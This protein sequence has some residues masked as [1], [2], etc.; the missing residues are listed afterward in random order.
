MHKFLYSFFLIALMFSLSSISYAQDAQDMADPSGVSVSLDQITTPNEFD[1]AILFDN[2]PII[3]L[4]GGGCSG[5]NASIL[6][7]TNGS[8]STF[9]WGFQKNLFNWMADD[10]TSTQQW[11]IDSIKFFSYQTGATASSI[12]GVYVQI[13]NGAPNLGTSSVVWGDTVTNRLGYT[14]FSTTY[15]ALISTPADCNRRIQEVSALVN[16]TLPPGTYWVQFAVTGSLSS[17]PWC[18]PV[19]IAGTLV[20]GDALQKTTT[21]P[22]WAP[23]LNGTSQ[24]GAPFMIYGT[25]T[26]PTV[27]NYFLNHSTGTFVASV[28][29]DGF[30]GDDG[31]EIAAGVKFGALPNAMYTAGVVL[32]NSTFGVSGKVGSFTS[33]T[34][35]L[36]NDM[37]NKVLFVPFSSNGYFNQITHTTYTDSAAPV[38][39]YLDVK[40]TSYSRT[41]DNYMFIVYDVTNNTASAKNGI[42]VGMFADWDVGYTLYVQNRGGMDVPRSMTYQYLFNNAADPNYYGLVAL[43]GMTG[44]KVTTRFPGDG[45][46][47]R[48]ILYNWISTIQDSAI[49]TSGDYRSYIGSGPYNIAP[50]Q[51]VKVGYAMVIGSSLAD[52]QAKADMAWSVYHSQIVPVELTSFAASVNAAGHVILN[53]TTGTEINNLLFEVER[54]V[55]NNEFVRVGYVNGY[56]TTPE[57]QSYSFVDQSVTSGKYF[58]RLKQIDYSGAYEYSNVIEVDVRGPLG[59]GLSQNYPNPFNPS[60][61]IEFS[62]IEAGMV[63]LTVYNLLGEE[64]Q[65]LRNEYLQPG[66]YQTNFDAANLPSGMYIYKLETANH[67]LAR[68]MMLMK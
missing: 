37:K 30:F 43:N 8:H 41:G 17:G 44:G 40:Q 29:N 26:Q 48:G 23:A 55:G 4:P 63:K 66:F 12:T 36:V 62:I 6:D 13:W 68:K 39:Y 61:Q 46:T 3:T 35:L 54:S 47:I 15:R 21:N 2:G 9:G 14:A 50:G 59:F 5:G 18:P 64:I 58:Y 27:P 60:T 24:N 57:P 52:L 38:P 34:S 10:F 67:V 28:F 42:H 32:G 25:A 19:T 20:T 11:T 31:T 49:T 51:T 53:W 33:G 1:A 7:N 16:V 22:N 65:I 56:G 45:N